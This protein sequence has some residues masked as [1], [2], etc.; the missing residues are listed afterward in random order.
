MINQIIEYIKKN[1]E[2]MSDEWALA[3]VPFCE[4]DEEIVDKLDVKQ[5]LM[6]NGDNLSMEDIMNPDNEIGIHIYWDKVNH[7]DSV[8]IGLYLFGGGDL[9]LNKTLKE[10]LDAKEYKDIFDFGYKQLEIEES[11]RQDERDEI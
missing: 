11:L 4:L 10:I 8:E 1:I 6:K 3:T 5:T 2:V 9:N 7:P